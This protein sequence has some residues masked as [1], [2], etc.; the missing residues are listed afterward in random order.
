M[1]QSISW[2]IKSVWRLKSVDGKDEKHNAKFRIFIISISQ[3]IILCKSFTNNFFQP[4][5]QKILCHTSREGLICWYNSNY[6]KIQKRIM[7]TRCL[8]AY[9]IY[10]CIL[11]SHASVSDHLCQHWITCDSI[12]SLTEVAYSTH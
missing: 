7:H 1:H 6:F 11:K 5:N 9:K 2:V 4:D 12:G 10:S 8:A 3:K